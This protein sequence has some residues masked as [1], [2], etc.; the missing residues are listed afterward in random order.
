MSVTPPPESR[1]DAELEALTVRLRHSPHITTQHSTWLLVI[2]AAAFT[3][4]AIDLNFNSAFEGESF[5]ILMGRSVLAGASDVGAYMRGAFGW[6]LWPAATAIADRVGGLTAL[7]LL[8]AT[9]GT[10]AV[11]GVFMLTRRLFDERTGLVAA[12]FFAAFTPAIL[13]SRI[14]TPDAAGMALLAFTLAAFVR[15]WQTGGWAAWI[16]A[17]LLAI[18]CVLVKHSLAAIIPPL[19][20][21]APFLNRRR[22]WVFTLAVP[23]AL[24]F[25]AFWYVGVLRE[26][27][28]T[29]ANSESL[30]SR[31]ADLA[32][33]YVRNSLDVWVIG[34]LALVAFVRGDRE[35]RII[36]GIL[37]VL[38]ITLAIVPASRTFDPHA[39]S[40]T[41]YPVLLLLP[42]AAAGALGLAD[43]LVKQDR[44]LASA[45]ITI[46]AGSLIL[47]SGHGLSPVR[48]GLPVVW[49]NTAVVEDFLRTR[50]QY[51]QRILVDDA[52]L[53]YLLSDFT[54]QDHI[55]D[56]HMLTFGG[57][58]AP[59]SFA[60]AINAGYFDYVVLDGNN[61]EEARA[62]QLAIDPQVMSR[63]VE[64]LRT[65]QP[66]TGTDAVIYERVTP[67]VTRPVDA[68]T[69]IVESPQPGATVLAAGLHPSTIVSGH[70]ERNVPGARV[71]FDVMTDDWYAQG[72][73][74]T[75]SN[76]GRF[77]RRV[78]LGGEGSSRCAHTIRVRLLASDNRI[79]HEVLVSGVT[80]STQDSLAIP[81]PALH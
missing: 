46:T 47:I 59:E 76:S 67:P 62:L 25:Y 50:M 80:R 24:A 6:Y 43:R 70:V 42:A 79:L 75:P 65:L 68:P 44:V 9:L 1:R 34:I 23:L 10:V 3:I 33:L 5:M 11:A 8:A 52:A 14:A 7:R 39:W 78:V 74:L 45:L 35:A 12:L 58:V 30:R 32:T 27:L 48:G 19:C 31:D 37:A 61:T 36:V 29:V 63:Y 20:L 18:T 77:A 55:A 4:R 40:H 64:R 51:G 56:E 28:A 38:A 71:K 69:I 81:C 57:A 53:R 17:S 73:P 41:V 22:G 54:P 49:P 15:A 66:N 16:G 2:L 26:M 72:E 60:R 21:L 13:A